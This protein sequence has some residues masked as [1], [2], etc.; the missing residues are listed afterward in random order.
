M[1]NLKSLLGLLKLE[2]KTIGDESYIVLL[3]ESLNNTL[4]VQVVRIVLFFVL[5]TGKLFC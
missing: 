2:L 5:K 4:S 3:V 1:L